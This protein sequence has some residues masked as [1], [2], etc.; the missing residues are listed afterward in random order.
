MGEFGEREPLLPSQVRDAR[1]RTSP[2]VMTA[3]EPTSL[4]AAGGR[5]DHEAPRLKQTR[6]AGAHQHD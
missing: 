3:C 5:V 2:L 4:A 6:Y 1:A